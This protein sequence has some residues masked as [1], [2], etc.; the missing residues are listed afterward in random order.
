MIGG[1]NVCGGD[2][3][4]LWTSAKAKASVCTRCLDNGLRDTGFGKI[5]EGRVAPSPLITRFY[6]PRVKEELVF[7]G[8]E[9]A[10]TLEHV[11]RA[12]E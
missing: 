12:L 4:K 6:G 2:T 11:R 8:I 7:W 1:C 5:K 10:I 3:S 9:R